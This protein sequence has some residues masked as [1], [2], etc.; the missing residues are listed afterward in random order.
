ML[1][2]YL[3]TTAQ[4][5]PERQLRE[6]YFTFY[7]DKNAYAALVQ[8]RTRDLRACAH[9][10]RPVKRCL[11]DLM[12][13]IADKLILRAWEAYLLGVVN[14]IL[15]VHGRHISPTYFLGDVSF[16]GWWY[17]FQWSMP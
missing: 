12:I 9:G 4:Y 10:L 8:D 14:V 7:E 15:H 13:F 16:T 5:P 2:P 3:W 11:A 17:Y 6:T 1:L